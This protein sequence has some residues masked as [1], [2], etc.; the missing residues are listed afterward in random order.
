MH[1]RVLASQPSYASRS[2]P[3]PDDYGRWARGWKAS[4]YATAPDYA[5]R[6]CRIIEEAQLYLLDRPQGEALYAARNRARAQLR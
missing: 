2:V 3:P 5:Q 1:A 6:L 4:G